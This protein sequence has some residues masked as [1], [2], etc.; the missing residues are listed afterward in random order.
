MGG[1]WENCGYYCGPQPGSAWTI[2]SCTGP[3]P[4]NTS[5]E[6]DVACGG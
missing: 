4:G 2:A 6:Y 5:W 3:D 1:V